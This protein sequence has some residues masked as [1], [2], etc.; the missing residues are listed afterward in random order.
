M[1]NTI[2]VAFLDDGYLI[3]GGPIHHLGELCSNPTL[4]LDIAE[5]RKPQFPGK[6]FVLMT[7]KEWIKEC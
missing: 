1:N 3:C 2:F 7:V 5:G 6:R 4:Y